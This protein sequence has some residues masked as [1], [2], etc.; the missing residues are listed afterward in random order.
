MKLNMSR[1][2]DADGR[3]KNAHAAGCSA[4]ATPAAELH[5]H[6]HHHLETRRESPALPLRPG[7]HACFRPAP[8]PTS[9]R[10]ALLSSRTRRA[11]TPTGRDWFQRPARPY[12]A[13]PSNQLTHTPV[14]SRHGPDAARTAPDASGA[15]RHMHPTWSP[16]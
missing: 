13:C 8:T 5:A 7:L 6:V 4:H 15:C 11:H 2:L 12:L 16:P 10:P 9:P 14:H 3:R 1:L